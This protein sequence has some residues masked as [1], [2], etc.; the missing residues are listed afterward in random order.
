MFWRKKKT[1]ESPD[2]PR[3]GPASAASSPTQAPVSAMSGGAPGG[4]GVTVEKAFTITG[5]GVV[6]TGVVT[7]GTVRVGQRA[8]VYRGSQLVAAAAIIGV[9]G[10]SGERLEAGEPGNTVGLLLQTEERQQLQAGDQVVAT[11]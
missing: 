9:V 1:S 3:F 5:S 10:A 7:G 11:G 4:P 6:A 8:A 2:D